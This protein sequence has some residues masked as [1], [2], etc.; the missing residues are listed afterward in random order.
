[1]NT[2]MALEPV[3]YLNGRFVPRSQASL[4]VEDRGALFGDGVYEVL[5]YYHGKPLAMPEHVARLDRS[6][7]EVGLKSSPD[8]AQ[9]PA[10][11]DELLSRNG[12]SDAK[13]YWQVTR[14]ASTPR[15]HAFP[16]NTPPTVL[17]IAYPEKPLDPALP[18]R[19]V[20]AILH[21]DERWHRCHIKSLMLLPNVMARNKAME[22]GAY[23]A[24]FHRGDIVTE[25][26]C[27]SLFMVRKG[28][29][30]THPADQWILPG[31]TRTLVLR[32]ARQAGILVRE[33]TFTVGELLRAD[34]VFLCGTTTHIA[35]VTHIDNQAITSGAVG[36]LTQRLHELFM[37]R[38]AKE[39]YGLVG[40]GC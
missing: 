35:G 38:I 21:E 8:V 34:E 19:G 10:V 11:S 29:L 32:L 27:T 39:C 12:L 28:S 23:E 33:R 5:R 18:A 36:P 6:L 31:V 7:K 4:D 26:T 40:S 2:R 17:A 22:L 13:L 15:E 14:G 3:V 16:K 9:L 20:A 25:A 37:E 1:M 30:V 24:I